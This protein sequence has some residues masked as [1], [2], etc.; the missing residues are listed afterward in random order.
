MGECGFGFFNCSAGGCIDIN[1]VCD[2]S[3]DCLRDGDN[4]DEEGCRKLKFNFYD[5]PREKEGEKEREGR[6]EKGGERGR[7]RESEGEG[8]REGERLRQRKCRIIS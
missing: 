5:R 7:E 4:S 3:Y 8:G 6:M 1:L 2:G